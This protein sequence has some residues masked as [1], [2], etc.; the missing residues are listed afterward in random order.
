[1][2]CILL[3]NTMNMHK[4]KTTMPIFVSSIIIEDVY[5]KN[6]SGN[7]IWNLKMFINTQ[8][9]NLAQIIPFYGQVPKLEEI[10]L[11]SSHNSGDCCTLDTKWQQSSWNVDFSSQTRP[12][13]FQVRSLPPYKKIQTMWC[14][15][16][17]RLCFPRLLL[18]KGHWLCMQKMLQYDTIKDMMEKWG[19]RGIDA[20]CV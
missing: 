6:A 10:I 4:S 3:H 9:T 16:K 15:K 11:T 1:M 17:S 13:Q 18:H 12:L 2:L 5:S 20:C 8:N 14:S 19:S 7:P